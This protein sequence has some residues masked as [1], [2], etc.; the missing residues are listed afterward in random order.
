[1]V[2]SASQD[3]LRNV[4]VNT[5]DRHDTYV[6]VGKLVGPHG[7]RG[8]VKLRSFTAQPEDIFRYMPVHDAE[9]TP[10]ALHKCGTQREV[11][12]VRI[13]GVQ[14]RTQAEQLC[15]RTLHAP[16]EALER[17]APAEE[18]E[19]YY[20]ELR[21]MAVRTEAGEIWGKV[22][23]VHNFGA[24]DILEVMSEGA[25]QSQM[26]P[27]THAVFPHI[28]RAARVITYVP[29]EYVSPSVEDTTD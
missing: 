13:D 5:Q 26:L 1:M 11:F 21:H 8:M 3:V 2:S 20:H 25:Q 17:L 12:L 15:P 16:R 6:A 23:A 27:F 24:G 14:T 4:M 19:F 7:I 22:V 18:D 9:G 28:D 10:Y 29:A